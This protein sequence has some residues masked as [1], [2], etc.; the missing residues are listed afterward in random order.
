MSGK[1]DISG[2]ENFKSKGLNVPKE[3]IEKATI[4]KEEKSETEE[5]LEGIKAEYEKKLEAL[6]RENEILASSSTFTKNEEKLL[7]AI[8]SEAL[9][10][11]KEEPVIGRTKLL[12]EYRI[13]SRY[14]DDAINGLVSKGCLE[15]KSVKYS[16]KITTYSWKL[17]R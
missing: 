17:L 1:L 9:I 13:N 7:A 11:D 15:R 8:R 14:F 2:L 6:K 10:Q 5:G 4:L 16:T 12:K 3:W